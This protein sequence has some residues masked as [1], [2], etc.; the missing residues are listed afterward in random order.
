MG[1]VELHPWEAQ[2]D[3]VLRSHVSNK[4]IRKRSA[5]D[6]H[7]AMTP[8]GL[9]VNGVDAKGHVQVVQGLLVDEIAS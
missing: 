4:L 7:R 5:P 1:C 6:V 8:H 2:D 3:R 9:S